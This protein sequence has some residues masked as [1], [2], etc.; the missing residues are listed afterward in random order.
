MQTLCATVSTNNYL[1]ASLYDAANPCD[2]ILIA[3]TEYLELTNNSNLVFDIDSALFVD[4]TFYLLL[5]FL[6]GHILGRIVKALGRA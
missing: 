5:S 4:V 3:H 2:N 1:V 6:S